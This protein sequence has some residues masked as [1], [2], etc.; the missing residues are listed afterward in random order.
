[1]GRYRG[2]VEQA[3]QELRASG[4]GVREARELA[5]RLA[6]VR[7]AAADRHVRPYPWLGGRACEGKATEDD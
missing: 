3:R 1:M 7:Q 2:T 5:P 6:E 4:L